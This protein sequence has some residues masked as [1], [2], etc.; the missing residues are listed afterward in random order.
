MTARN[1]AKYFVRNDVQNILIK[2]AGFDLSKIF[3]P[4]FNIN[5]QKSSISL[6][7]HEQ[8]ERVRHSIVKSLNLADKELTFFFF[9]FDQKENRKAEYKAF[10]LMQMPPFLNATKTDAVLSS[11]EK[12]NPLNL[13]NTNYIFTD[14]S[15][16][17]SD[18]VIC[19][20]FLLMLG[21]RYQIHDPFYTFIKVTK[22]KLMIYTMFTL[23]RYK[24]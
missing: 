5:Q 7:T 16:N 23:H 8:L 11:D 12:L 17:I 22:G 13:T 10:K 24:M 18:K 21:P 9:F 1:P 15:L 19:C 3:Q 2:L 20:L 6:L 4:R 14:I